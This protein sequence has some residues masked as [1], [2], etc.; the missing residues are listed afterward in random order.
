M[1][2]TTTSNYGLTKPEVGGSND[3]W[4]TKINAGL[5]T[6][7]ATMKSIS[8]VAN[9]ATTTAGNALPAATY[10]AADILAKLLGV[11]GTGSGL[12]ADKLDGK[13]AAEF[14]LASAY[15]AADVLAKLL[16]VDGVSSG[17][18]A[19]LL[20]GQQGSWY[21]DIPGRL[22]F[23]PANKAGD[24]FSG[25]VNFAA[26]ITGTT[27]TFSGD[28]TSS[29]DRRLKTDIRELDGANM[30]D[31]LRKIGGWSFTMN[32]RH[33]FGVIAQ[34]VQETA[35]RSIVYKDND[36]KLSVAY[37]GLIAPLIAAVLHLSDEVARLKGDK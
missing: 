31:E 33:R 36:G 5:D 14:V 2:D 10:T 3:S 29:S 20:D 19:D 15:T 6:I 34:D 8:D 25:V 17:L 16:G 1:A 23:T 7:D 11:D 12:D 4:G 26:N 9:A 18:D 13:E 32:E 22:G 27:A 24:S 21:A 30:I 37:T 28:I 35:L